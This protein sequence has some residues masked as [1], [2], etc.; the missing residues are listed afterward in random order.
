MK[1]NG[2][3]TYECDFLHHPQLHGVFQNTPAAALLQQFISR[4]SVALLP[5]IG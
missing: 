3:G 2:D 1:G 4:A 5:G